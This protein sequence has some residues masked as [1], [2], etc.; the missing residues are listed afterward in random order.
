MN[1]LMY[2]VGRRADACLD[3]LN[4]LLGD[5][6]KMRLPE[7]IIILPIPT[8]RDN[9]TLFGTNVDISEVIGGAS[10]NDLVVSYGLPSEYKEH[11]CGLGALE[12]DLSCD[13]G[14]LIPN[15]RLTAIATLGI[16]LTSSPL[17]IS[18]QRIGVVGY[19]RIGARLAAML[20]YLGT[21]VTV[22]TTR[23]DAAEELAEYGIKAVTVDSVA[24]PMGLDILVNTAPAALF[25]GDRVEF[26]RDIRVIELA[27]GDNFSG[28]SVEKYPSLP[29]KMYPLGAG[30][31]WANAIYNFLL[32][33]EKIKE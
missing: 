4:R 31:I 8:T 29:A 23:A 1:V 9:T 14:F 30:R 12:F 2:E 5:K 20:L 11:L 25:H 21:D 27:S 15:A 7:N 6:K 28:L 24:S 26:L 16:I 18:E 17:S 3:E 13:D 19:G 33:R 22:I 32:R 10:R